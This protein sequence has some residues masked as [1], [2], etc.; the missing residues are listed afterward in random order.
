MSE[1]VRRKQL[2][3]G[4]IVPIT[5]DYVFCNIFNN[6]DN[7]IILENFLACYLEVPLSKI[8]GHVEILSRNLI[9]E[10]KREANKQIDL[11]V[12]IDGEK[13]NIELQNKRSE[14]IINRN[15]VFAS[16]VHA[17]QLKINNEKGKKDSES[18]YAGIKRT[19]QINLM[20]GR[21]KKKVKESYFL[22]NEEGEILTKKLQI[23]LVNMEKA[24]ELCYTKEET[25]LARWCRV[26]LATTKEEFEEALGE[27]LMEREAKDLLEEKV[28]QYSRDEEVIE[29]Y[30]EYSR[31]EL[32]TESVL[33]EAKEQAIK[34]GREEG[35]EQG[36]KQG[37][38]EGREEGIQ[39][40]RVEIARRM[41]EEKMDKNIV[42]RI[43][44]LSIEE[45]EKL[46]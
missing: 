36:I 10:H 1:S 39:K 11:L 35:I 23:D 13:V 27:D 8:R 45:I 42:A 33:E 37:R 30:S 22:T 3:E 25:K 2:E 6:M 28:E 4:T 19:L 40:N 31:A 34:Q 41:L 32:E 43:T 44:D 24:K 29:M 7:I 12:D 20:R 14:G 46:G 26:I 38:E 15:V 17:G 16:K 21:D 5:F 18:K 9:I